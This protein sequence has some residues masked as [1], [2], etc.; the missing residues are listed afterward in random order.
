MNMNF[1]ANLAGLPTQK[2]NN[3]IA[4]CGDKSQHEYVLA[5][6]II[7]FRGGFPERTLGMQ[8]NLLMLCAH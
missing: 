5:T 4:L 3:S 8:N 7:A 2:D 6:T 1:G